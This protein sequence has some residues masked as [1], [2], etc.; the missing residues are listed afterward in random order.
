MTALYTCFMFMFHTMNHYIKK[1]F[2][3]KSWPENGIF[4][5]NRFYFFSS[6]VREFDLVVILVICGFYKTK[7]E[8]PDFPEF[9][10]YFSV[11][12]KN[13][14]LVPP[15]LFPPFLQKNSRRHN[16]LTKYRLFH[17]KPKSRPNKS[18]IWYF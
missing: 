8:S 17:K 13:F 18:R 11:S 16:L 3:V 5:K 15:L 12:R 10:V 1:K 9:R 2:S 4:G 14:P 6:N 7:F